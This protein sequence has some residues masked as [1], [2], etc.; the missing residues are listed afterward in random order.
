MVDSI[1][2]LLLTNWNGRK[3]SN[4]INEDFRLFSGDA[5]LP[6]QGVCFNFELAR[7]LLAPS[8]PVHPPTESDLCRRSYGFGTEL[9]PHPQSHIP[10][11]IPHPNPIP[12]T[13]IISHHITSPPQ[14]GGYSFEKNGGGTV[15][16]SY[17]GVSDLTLEQCKS[18]CADGTWPACVG[19]SRYSAPADTASASCW[20]V[21]NVGEL[22][23]DDDDENMYKLTY[24]GGWEFCPT[25]EL[26]IGHSF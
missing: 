16:G 4:M 7:S 17:T 2:S 13:H 19:F 23:Y 25:G 21:A 3:S 14:L 26:C 10:S 18:N 11:P 22:S 9:E 24:V 12:F 15:T 8:L 5:R 1:Y 6:A 20:W